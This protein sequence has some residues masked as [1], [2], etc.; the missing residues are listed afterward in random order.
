[1]VF[2]AYE[3]V[4]NII[5]MLIL[6]GV[7]ET[8]MDVWR[9]DM[10]QK[11]WIMYVTALIFSFLFVYIF[12]KGYEGKGIAEGIRYGLIIG[13]LMNIVGMFNQYAAYPISLSLTVQW[14]I[15]GVIQ[16]IIC[17]IVTAALYK[18]SK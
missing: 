18:P 2:V 1:M 4:N 16:I 10:M 9:T 3:A 5:H 7:Y 13:L 8:M 12:S 15:Y 6:S 17:G 14:F 11:L